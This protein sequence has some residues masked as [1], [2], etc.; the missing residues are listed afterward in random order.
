MYAKRVQFSRI[1]LALSIMVDAL[2]SGKSMGIDT[3]ISYKA[4]DKVASDKVASDKAASYQA[5]SY[6]KAV[7]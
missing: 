7:G 2:R 4:S 5:I 6:R 3:T 1:S